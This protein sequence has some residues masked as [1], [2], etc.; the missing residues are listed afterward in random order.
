[1]ATGC[2]WR[3]NHVNNLGISGE[4]IYS[5]LGCGIDATGG[6][7]DSAPYTCMMLRLTLAVAALCCLSASAF[8]DVVTNLTGREIIDRYLARQAVDSELAFIAMTVSRPGAPKKE[9]RFLLAYRREADGTKK[10]L[11]RLVRPKDVEGVSVL[12][13]QDPQGKVQA[14]VFMPAL[15]QSTRLAGSALDKPF[16]GSDYSYKDLM[17]EAPAANRY[18]RLKDAQLQGVDCYQVRAV[19]TQ[20]SADRLYGYRDLLIDKEK[21]QL[22]R[23]TFHAA[24]GKLI[25]TFMPY[26][27]GSTQVKG[28]TTRPHRAV[29][30]RAGVDEWTEFLVV[31]GRLNKDIPPEIFTIQKIES[32]KPQEVDEFIF[33]F[34]ITV[35]GKAT[36]Q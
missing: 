35:S 28:Q 18:E 2:H 27:Y 34:G 8:A 1:V 26:D 25:K 15:G 16:L 31:E 33:Q 32:W 11:V 14:H 5:R 12:A 29:M 30:V 10:G 3:D 6:I 23:I 21:L 4:W 36:E 19:E 22:V 20:S 24:N 7:V 17:A 13:V 9:N